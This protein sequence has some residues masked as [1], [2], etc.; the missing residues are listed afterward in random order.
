MSSW[1]TPLLLL[2]FCG[3]GV[4]T[5]IAGLYLSK[6][7][8][9]LDDRFA[10]GEAVGG[11]LLLGLAGSLPELA[12]ISSAA[13]SGHLALATGNV[14]GGI[15]MQTLVLVFLDA[16]SRQRRP[17][18]SLVSDTSPLFE[19]VLVV[20]LATLAVMGGLLPESTAIGPVSPASLAIVLLF[21]LGMI[22]LN[23]A[24][25]RAVWRAVDES[26]SVRGAAGQPVNL[27]ER[28]STAVVVGAFL[29]ASAVTLVAGVLLEQTGNQLADDFGMNGV[30][31]GATILAAVTA[32]PEVSS[33]I[34]AVRLGSVELAMS[35][36]YGGNAVQ[37]TFFLLADLLAGSPVLA[38][39][40]SESLWLGG[41][42][43]VVSA[44][45]AYGLLVRL[46]QKQFGL[47]RDS[48]LVLLIYVVGV[49]LLTKIP[50]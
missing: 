23:R 9:V 33:G 8:D 14:L 6:A 4:V 5:W 49:V 1:G 13:L 30:V 45:F 41:L 2:V 15:A 25:R 37:L 47:G 21:V 38:T 3:A 26:E 46:K 35:D 10:L 50:G 12:I 19:A 32:L 7:T 27:F 18:T 31:F 28:M 40:S 22:G 20:V 34:Q 42:G 29:A 11:M 24:R 36:I 43:V 39:A 17:L 44:I 48:L 16:T